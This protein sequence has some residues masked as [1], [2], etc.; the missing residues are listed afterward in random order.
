MIARKTVSLF[1]RFARVFFSSKELII[2]WLRF[3]RLIS[4]RNFYNRIDWP[5]KPAN[6]KCYFR[7]PQRCFS[8]RQSS[9]VFFD[10]LLCVNES[11]PL[12]ALPSVPTEGCCWGRNEVLVTKAITRF[13]C[14]PFIHL[15]GDFFCWK[16]LKSATLKWRVVIEIRPVDASK[17]QENSGIELLFNG[18]LFF[19]QIFL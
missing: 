16:R 12:F 11:K 8:T 1:N 15:G 13:F 14:L 2:F 7:S 5:D 3:T 6:E 19:S 18:P 17:W 9:Q 10:R 4:F